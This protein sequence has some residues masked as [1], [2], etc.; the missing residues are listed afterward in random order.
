MWHCCLALE[1]A[2]QSRTGIDQHRCDKRLPL[3]V[4]KAVIDGV[5]KLG[6][7]FL[8]FHEG[9]LIVEPYALINECQIA[10]A[11]REFANTLQAFV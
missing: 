2:Q 10:S 5:I 7:Q 8:R 4:A 11:Y 9:R 3:Q 6:E 1:Q